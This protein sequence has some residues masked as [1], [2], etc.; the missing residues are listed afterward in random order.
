[1]RVSSLFGVLLVMACRPAARPTPPAP[2]QVVVDASVG[3][4][5]HAAP[6]VAPPAVAEVTDPGCPATPRI[7]VVHRRYAPREAPDAAAVA[8]PW[9]MHEVFDGNVASDFDTSAPQRALDRA[10]AVRLGALDSDDPVWVYTAPDTPPCRATPGRFWW[11]PSEMGG[12]AYVEIVR[13][14]SGCEMPTDDATQLV[15][16][17]RQ[18]TRPARCMFRRAEPAGT[19]LDPTAHLPPEVAALIPS[20]PCPRARCRLLWRLTAARFEGGATVSELTATYMPHRGGEPDCNGAW[21]DFHTTLFQRAAGGPLARLDQAMR[22]YGALYDGAGP[23]IAISADVDTVRAHVL[24]ERASASVAPT[25]TAQWCRMNHTQYEG[26]GSL[27]PCC[28]L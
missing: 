5:T 14:L 13:E 2:L 27:A 15:I 1:M 3:A 10:E 6:P 23:R 9:V 8:T 22:L 11:V 19:H 26:R 28:Q 21:T 12:D 17:L 7:A 18:P 24:P 16:A 20:Q 25:M 4:S